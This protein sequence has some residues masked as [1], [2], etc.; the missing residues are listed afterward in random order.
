MFFFIFLA[1]FAAAFS[2]GAA[3]DV[4]EEEAKIFLDEF[5][6]L[7]NSLKGENFGVEIFAHNAEIA[8][9]MFIPGFGIGWGVFSAVST[10]F[11]FAALATTTPMLGNIPPV[12]LIFATP[13]GLM[14]LAAYSLAMSRSYY[15]ILAIFR[16]TPLKEQWK[17]LAIEIGIVIGLLLAGGIIEAYMIEHFANIK[18]F[19]VK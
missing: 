11:A 7:L 16:K 18:P 1:V 3:M 6:K 4:P 13:F 12:A 17:P 8:L 10:G 2:V 15:L 9:A 19:E 5:D 14:E